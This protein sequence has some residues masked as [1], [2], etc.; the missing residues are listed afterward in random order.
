MEQMVVDPGEHL[1]LISRV[2]SQ[3]NLSENERDE[4]FSESLIT[5]TEAARSYDP[6]KGIPVANWLGKN[7]RWGIYKWRDSQRR[8]Y[9]DSIEDMPIE[10]PHDHVNENLELKEVLAIMD[11]ILSPNERFIVLA[12]ALGYSGTSVAARLQIS[13]VQV[14][15][16]R[17]KAQDKLKA[18]VGK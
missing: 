3:M 18:R 11:E 7:I 16:I 8:R 13:P 10:H 1:R 12:T 5:I 4:A 2:I 14:S 9:A 15:R 17:R 6:S